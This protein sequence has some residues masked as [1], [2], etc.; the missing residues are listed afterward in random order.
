MFGNRILWLE[1]FSC[2]SQSVVW[3]PVC[4]R[5]LE[6][7]HFIALISL[8]LPLVVPEVWGS[9]GGGGESPDHPG[10]VEGPGAG[11]LI[12]TPRTEQPQPLSLQLGKE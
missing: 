5:V 9:E 8:S 3:L 6:H 11:S 7:R 1:Y 10:Q 2:P 4:S 12:H